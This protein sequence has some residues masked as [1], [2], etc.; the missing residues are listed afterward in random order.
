MIDEA[1]AVM[2]HHGAG[3]VLHLLIALSVASAAIAL[4]RAR[5]FWRQRRDVAGLGRELHRLLAGGDADAARAAL[6]RTGGVAADVALAGLARW[7][8][9]AQ[10]AREAM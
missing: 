1:K 10:A 7:E 3:W 6:I 2:V 4:D 8:A 5:V 9:G